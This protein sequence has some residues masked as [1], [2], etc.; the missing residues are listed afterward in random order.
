MSIHLKTALAQSLIS[1]HGSR[2]LTKLENYRQ[3][4]R[5]FFDV[6]NSLLDLIQEQ[7]KFVDLYLFCFYLLKFA[8]NKL[9]YLITYLDQKEP[10][11]ELLRYL[12]DNYW[13]DCLKSVHFKTIQN[14]TERWIN[15]VKKRLFKLRVKTFSDYYSQKRPD[16]NAEEEKILH[17]N[18]N[19]DWGVSADLSI[20][21]PELI[22]Q[23]KTRGM[24]LSD[25]N[26]K[27]YYELCF[28]TMIA[29]FMDKANYEINL[30]AFKEDCNCYAYYCNVNFD[31]YLRPR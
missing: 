23:L 7:P 29:E 4:C 24:K 21:L 16:L 22:S 15:L 1:D 25:Q 19:K 3:C 12:E 26:R 28:A 8:H 20:R 18:I 14:S 13:T 30:E 11:R 31:K 9:S 17:E 27:L 2:I 10:P 5:F 6:C